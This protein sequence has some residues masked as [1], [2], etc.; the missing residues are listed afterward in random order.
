MS[1]S[2]WYKRWPERLEFELQELR[3]SNIEF[4]QDQAALENGTVQLE[5][6]YPAGPV[7]TRL[8]VTYPDLYPYFRFDVRALDLDLK[9]HQ[10]PFSK[11][12]CLMGRATHF[13]DSDLT[14]ARV[15][16]DQFSTLLKT[17]STLDREAVQ[18]L[19][20]RQAE[21]IGEF[22]LYADSMILIPSDWKIDSSK[23]SG[24]LTIGAIMPLDPRR[25]RLR[26]AVVKIQDETGETLA[27]AQNSVFDMY[28]ETE[29]EGQWVRIS[30]PIRENDP[31]L[32][33]KELIGKYPD[34]RNRR[35]RRMVGFNLQIWGVLFPEEISH[36]TNGEGWVFIVKYEKT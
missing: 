25:Q 32:F 5:L 31:N 12:L 33:L 14:I 26:G 6:K 2:P 30:E 23:K 22:Y 3:D 21:P 29:I 9:Y 13:W 19:E 27:S 18:G 1:S 15:L 34:S 10:N 11:S 8:V 24:R 36:R 20:Q 17:A 28:N 35:V 16:R 4:S 7:T